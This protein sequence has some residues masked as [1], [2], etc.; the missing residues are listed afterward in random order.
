MIKKI[1]VLLFACICLFSA[2]TACAEE[3]VHEYGEWAVTKEAECEGLGTKERLCSCG[4]KEQGYLSALGHTFENNV[5][6]LCEAKA[7]EGF[8]FESYGDGTCCI[9]GF[10]KCTDFELIFPTHSPSGD[11]VIDI[12]D[13]VVPRDGTI[14]K[15]VFPN[16]LIDL[17]EFN[18]F[19]GLETVVIP[20]ITEIQSVFKNCPDLKNICIPADLTCVY[21]DAFAG[22]V[23]YNDPNNWENG[24]LYLEN[25]LLT[26]KADVG[27]SFAVKKG[28]IL[29][30]RYAFR[31]CVGLTDV[32]LPES[33]EKI[34][35]GAFYTCDALEELHLPQNVSRVELGFNRNLKKITVDKNNPVYHVDGNCLIETENKNLVYGVGSCVIPTD[36]SVT[37]IGDSAF[38]QCDTLT[39]LV[40]PEAITEISDGAFSGCKT[41]KS[42]TLHRN[43]DIIN[44]RV[45]QNCTAL[46]RIDIG[47]PSIFSPL[48]IDG[49]FNLKEI[50]YHGTKAEWES[51]QKSWDREPKLSY[52]VVCTDGTIEK[53]K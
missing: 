13:T 37:S 17:D 47:K 42:A 51:V 44:R 38:Y 14:K 22:S 24:A 15:I 27:E 31:D 43:I 8:W 45:F 23:Y 28:T 5:C 12:R 34:G 36:G 32:I 1:F 9:T 49:C 20:T 10:G 11:R 18:G 3:H 19:R 4:E 21:S 48:A 26:V 33:T 6:V 46:E 2:F 40:I 39:E 7:S 30:A 29:I 35:Y 53:T 50:I 25:Y 52:T 16:T 41:L